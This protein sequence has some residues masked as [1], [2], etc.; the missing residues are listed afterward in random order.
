[1]SWSW[2]LLGYGAL[3]AVIG[4]LGSY[5]VGRR[6]QL[7]SN[8]WT[9]YR[10]FLVVSAAVAVLAA[11]LDSAWPLFVFGAYVVLANFAIPL[12][13]LNR[14]RGMEGHKCASATESC[15]AEACAACPLSAQAQASASNA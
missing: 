8:R 10:G 2:V 14:T 13:L 3:I 5:V 7:E 6:A 9:A 1:M 11:S 15:S 12:L 4:V